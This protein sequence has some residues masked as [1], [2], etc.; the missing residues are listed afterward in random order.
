MK[1]QQNILLLLFAV[2]CTDQPYESLHKFEQGT[3]IHID[4]DIEE[5]NKEDELDL[6]SDPFNPLPYADQL[7][8]LATGFWFVEGP[9]WRD[10]GKLLFSD[11]PANKIYLLENQDLS[12]FR[13]NSYHSNGLY[14]T[15]EGDLFIAEHGNRRVAMLSSQGSKPVVDQFEGKRL[16]SPNDLLFHSNGD[17]FFT[18]PPYGIEEYEREQ[19][20]NHVFRYTSSGELQSIWAGDVHSRPN[21][22]AI[23]PDESKLFV[24]DT[25]ESVIR[26]FALDESGNPGDEKIFAHVSGVA[27][28][29]SVDPFGNIYVATVAGIEIISPS[30]ELWG[31]IPL[32]KQ[33]SNCTFGGEEGNILYITAIDSVFAL[34]FDW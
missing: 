17:L 8:I 22:I 26:S 1:L 13:N 12:I 30:G 14:E 31:T 9:L 28:G 11:I 2:G 25:Q 3:I 21:G 4:M 19:N 23:S 33:P 20:H 16:N 18:D 34:S 29:M 27:D 32:P 24:S 10:D 15:P 5:E 7:E 6:S